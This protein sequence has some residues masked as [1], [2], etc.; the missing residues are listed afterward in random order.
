[1]IGKGNKVP[2]QHLNDDHCCKNIV[3]V[4]LIATRLSDFY[5]PHREIYYS[6]AS[7]QK[8][9]SL[10]VEKI[11]NIGFIVENLNFDFSQLEKV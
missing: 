10:E 11:P 5:F 8:K 9:K 3:Q 1:M 7:S 4:L 2:P 6:S